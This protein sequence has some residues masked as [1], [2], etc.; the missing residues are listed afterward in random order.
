MTLNHRTE[1]TKQLFCEGTNLFRRRWIRASRRKYLKQI[2]GLR[3]M[4]DT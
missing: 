1:A 3:L 4:I 2:V